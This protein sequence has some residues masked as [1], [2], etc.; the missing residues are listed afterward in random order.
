MLVGGPSEEERSVS[1]DG[2]FE[3]LLGHNKRY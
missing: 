2:N 1:D 3:K